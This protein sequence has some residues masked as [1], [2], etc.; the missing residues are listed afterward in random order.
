MEAGTADEDVVAAMQSL[1]SRART[2]VI[3]FASF[4]D[5]RLAGAI[6]LGDAA[7]ST[8]AKQAMDN[9]ADFPAILRNRLGAREIAAQL[10]RH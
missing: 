5:S 2:V 1:P 9:A 3:L 10:A 7:A 6:L 8:G 4:A